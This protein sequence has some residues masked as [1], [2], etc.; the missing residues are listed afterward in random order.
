MINQN[1]YKSI[2]KAI[3][4]GDF[5]DL[6]PYLPDGFYQDFWEYYDR[7]NNKPDKLEIRKLL[8]KWL[9]PTLMKSKISEFEERL[10]RGEKL[11]KYRVSHPLVSINFIV[12]AENSED[13]KEEFRETIICCVWPDVPDSF[14]EIN[15]TVELIG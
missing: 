2:E 3:D 10:Q 9:W 5:S 8:I 12:E 13:A 11:Q 15:P 7:T 6:K 1:L 14:W 4:T